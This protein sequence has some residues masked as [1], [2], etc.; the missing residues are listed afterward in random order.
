MIY[1]DAVPAADLFAM[2][3]IKASG[4]S[5]KLGEIFTYKGEFQWTQNAIDEINAWNRAGCPPTPEHSKLR[6]YNGRRA[7][8][9]I[10]LAMISSASRGTGELVVT[11]DDFERAK[12]W[13]I[14]AE[15]TMPDIFRA[16]GQKSDS[17]VIADM[18]FHIYRIWSSVSL[19]KRKPINVQVIYEFLHSRVPSD[20]IARLIDVAEKTGYIKKGPYPDEYI[21]QLISK[22]FGSI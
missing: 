6:H 12:D 17:Q 22:N 11:V 8:H 4:L 16:M 19:D 7:L 20:K 14:E 10:K 18:H 9:T 13:L 3:E 21:P 1:A 15:Q 2:R 5:A